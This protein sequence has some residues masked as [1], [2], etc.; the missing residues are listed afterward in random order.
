MLTGDL[1]VLTASITRPITT[2]M[3]EVL[4]TSLCFPLWK[5]E[6]S[7]FLCNW[8]IF[9]SLLFNDVLSF[10]LFMFH[11][12]CNDTFNL[13]YLAPNVRTIDNNKYLQNLYEVAIVSWH[14]PERTEKNC[15]KI[16]RIED[17]WT[18]ILFLF[19]P[20]ANWVFI[21]IPRL[22]RWFGIFISNSELINQRKCL[23]CYRLMNCM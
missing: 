20:S 2:L 22:G 8:R 12:L 15:E 10:Y 6:I 17:V 1:E 23:R 14:L 11:V 13:Y 3:M 9:L 7:Q 18:V 16:V 4:R 19:I 21:Q 5:L